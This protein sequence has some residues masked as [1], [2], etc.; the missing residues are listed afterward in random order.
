MV[1]VWI[2][3]GSAVA[4]AACEEDC[5]VRTI[6]LPCPT[7]SNPGRTCPSYYDEPVCVTRKLACQG[8]LTACVAESM[9]AYGAGGVCVAAVYADLNVGGAISAQ[10]TLICAVAAERIEATIQHCR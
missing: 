2:V 5:R 4:S 9:V 10:T 7:W 3:M 6:D 1:G 8:R